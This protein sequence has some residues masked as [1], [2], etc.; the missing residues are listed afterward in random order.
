ML[1]SFVQRIASNFLVFVLK[2]DQFIRY[3]SVLKGV[4]C[5]EEYFFDEGIL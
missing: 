2:N 4:K 5:P 1:S 3:V